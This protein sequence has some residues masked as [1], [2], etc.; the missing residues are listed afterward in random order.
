MINDSSIWKG[1]KI[2]NLYKS[3]ETP[4]NWHKEIFSFGKKSYF[5]F[6]AP[7]DLIIN[8]LNKLN[9]PMFKIASPK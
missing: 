3:V 7:F 1:K 5:C 6:S 8:L 9:C 4:F 2:Y